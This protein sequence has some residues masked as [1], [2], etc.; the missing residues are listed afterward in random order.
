MTT[1]TSENNDSCW[2][3]CDP[4]LPA[5]NMSD[6]E[7]YWLSEPESIIGG[8][9]ALFTSIPG[10][11][12]NF[13]VILTLI[14]NQ[15]LRKEYLAPSIASITITDFLFSLYVLPRESLHF[16]NRDVTWFEGCNFF[17]LFS[18]GLW[19]VSIFNL[20]GIAG[21]RCFAISYP[22]KTRGKS[23]QYCCVIVPIMAWASTL[24]LFL[25]SLT[26]QY[27]Q[28]GLRCNFFLC[29]FVNVDTEG[30]P[31]TLGPL[32]VYLMIIAFS[33]ILLL[34]LNVLG[35]IQ[36]S[37]HSQKIFDQIKD[38]N[39]DTATKVLQNEK[40]LQK[41]VRLVTAAFFLVYVP[42][43]LLVAFG[44]EGRD[45]PMFAVICYFCA[46]LLV[47][48]DPLIYIYSSEK[49]RN[50]IKSILNPMFSRIRT[51]N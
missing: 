9:M 41:M 7:S 40:K 36:V 21:L 34:F 44:N 27:G 10:T 14:R 51:L 29:A 48:L 42:L 17:G 15:E 47:I 25:P 46:E 37:K 30:N 11:I 12:L 4:S 33:G 22:L 38:I 3:E 20:I 35:Y 49:F 31:I 24:I 26:R 1:S 23:F 16:F 28:I 2:A 13:L 6:Y 39:V 8:I 32:A 5:S 43:V 50:G 19:M 45:T 18:M